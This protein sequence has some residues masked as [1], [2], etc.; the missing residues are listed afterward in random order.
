MLIYLKCDE[1][2]KLQLD[3]PKKKI[4]ALM[5]SL[6][7]GRRVCP[8]CKP[9]DVQL[10]RVDPP[11]DELVGSSHKK[12]S[13][14]KGHVIEAYAFTN[15]MVGY[16]W[17]RGMEDHENIPGTP[18]NLMKMFDDGEIKCCH[19]VEGK[20]NKMRK[21]KCKLKPVDNTILTIPGTF[22]FKTKTR[23]GDIWDKEKF[24]EPKAS[25][26]ESFKNE[27]DGRPDAKFVETEFTRR[28][29]RRIAKLKEQNKE[30]AKRPD[31]TKVLKKATKNKYFKGR[32]QA[33]RKGDD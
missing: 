22:N 25:H 17:G 29:K 9:K 8:N 26:W 13:C 15:G 24:P 16:E 18:E 12:Y 33:P 32:P 4:P 30:K 19:L 10:H 20:N 5:R 14:S 3:L 11:E 6:E 28:S 27:K 7:S 23:V 21:C 1:G 2:H 31:N